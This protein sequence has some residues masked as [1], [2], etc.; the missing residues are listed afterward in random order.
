MSPEQVQGF[1]L[2]HR[3][4][5]FSLGVVLHGMATGQRP[6]RGVSSADLFASILRDAAPL[7]VRC[8]SAGVGSTRCARLSVSPHRD[9]SSWRERTGSTIIVWNSSL[10]RG[11]A[12]N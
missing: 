3:T 6:F 7:V 12:G 4:D 1:P 5:I 10:M 2:D 11:V 8:S 9:Y